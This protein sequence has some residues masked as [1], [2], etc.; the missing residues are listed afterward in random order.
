MNHPSGPTINLDRVCIIIK[1]LNWNKNNI[2]GKALVTETP[3][4]NILKGLLESGA[5][6]G[7]STRGM[8]E[9]HRRDDGVMIVKPGYYLSTA[10]DVVADPSAPDAFV[11]G[12]MENVEWFYDESN[13]E[14]IQEKVHSIKERVKKMSMNDIESEKL[15][16]FENFINSLKNNNRLF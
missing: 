8:G 6:L 16:V 13:G 12:I 14:W 15:N 7:V 11:K 10:A 4:G 2:H 3:M 1:E 5:Q 9:L